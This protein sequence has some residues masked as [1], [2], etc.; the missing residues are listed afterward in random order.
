MRL[1]SFGGVSLTE[2]GGEDSIPRSARSALVELPGGAFD[3]DG[4]R[5]VFTTR[6]ISRRM[7]LAGTDIDADLDT[8][9]ASLAG[10]R[11][12]LKAILRDESTYRQTWG[13]M[14]SVQCERGA[15]N[16]GQQPVIVTWLQ[17]YPYWLSTADEPWY[18]D[19]G[20]VLDDSLTLDDANVTTQVLTGS[21]TFTITNAG[22]AAIPRGRIVITVV[23]ASTASV[24]TIRNAANDMRLHYAGSLTAGDVLEFDLLTRTAR[25]N[26]STDAYADIINPDQ[27]DWQQLEVGANPITVTAT[28]TGT[29]TLTWYWS[30]HYV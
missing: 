5:G 6:Q 26:Y 27:V 11:R 2:Y 13:K 19:H 18:L 25:L 28:I 16:V 10:G 29:V 14:L 15:G 30:R 12:L 7:I 22:T 9:L 3:Q 24:I 23:A 4:A 8:L 17:D 21:D 1:V 20:E